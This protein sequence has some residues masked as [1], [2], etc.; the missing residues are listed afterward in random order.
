MISVKQTS[1]SPLMGKEVG[2]EGSNDDQ[3][4]KDNQEKE[5]DEDKDY[6]SDDFVD[7]FD[8]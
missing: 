4:N 7:A 3:A 6:N 2:S 1:T 5:S 8:N